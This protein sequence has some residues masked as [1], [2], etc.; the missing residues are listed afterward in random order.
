MTSPELQIR[1]HD[2]TTMSRQVIEWQGAK[3]DYDLEKSSKDEIETIYVPA[4]LHHILFELFKNAMR[5]T[6]E[7]HGEHS[8]AYPPI[9]V[10]VIKSPEDL[11]IRVSDRGGGIPRR[12][13][14]R[15]FHYLYTTAPNPELPE[16]GEEDFRYVSL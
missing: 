12:L 5:A 13:I 3:G 9:K 15:A 14:D 1:S 6:I 10:T 16:A 11:T 2:L 4:H 8:T 7:H